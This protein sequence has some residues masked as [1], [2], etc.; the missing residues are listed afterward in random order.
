[1]KCSGSVGCHQPRLVQFCGGI[2]YPGCIVLSADRTCQLYSPLA[3][4]NLTGASLCSPFAVRRV[5][6]YPRS[7]GLL[8]QTAP[9][10]LMSWARVAMSALMW[11]GRLTLILRGMSTVFCGVAP[12]VVVGP[13]VVAGEP[14]VLLL[15]VSGG[16]V[17]VVLLSW[18]LGSEEVLLVVPWVVMG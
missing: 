10:R 2:W 11:S 1:V 6:L 16:L 18:P 8:F 14:S 7:L 13:I 17:S 9:V 3:N 4:I 5:A 15:W 12:A